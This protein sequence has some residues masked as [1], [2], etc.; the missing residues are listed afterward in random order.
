MNRRG[1]VDSECDTACEVLSGI[2]AHL[3]SQISAD[4]FWHQPQVAAIRRETP[5]ILLPDSL[6]HRS[7]ITWTLGYS[8]LYPRQ[9][10]RYH[11]PFVRALTVSPEVVDGYRG[12][13]T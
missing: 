3:L 2:V 6:R 4:S 8:R 13:P 7:C 10:T 11:F 9:R 5:V 12:C 1:R